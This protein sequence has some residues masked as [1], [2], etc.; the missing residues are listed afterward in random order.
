MGSGRELGGRARLTGRDEGAKLVEER[1]AVF[2]RQ[3]FARTFDGAPDAV[4]VLL[5]GAAVESHGLVLRHEVAD[6]R[7]LA[8][9]HDDVASRLGRE[10][11]GLELGRGAAVVEGEQGDVVHAAFQAVAQRRGRQPGLAAEQPGS[12]VDPVDAVRDRGPAVRA[13]PLE[14]QEVSLQV[15][16]LADAPGVDG[17]LHGAGHRRETEDVTHLDDPAAFFGESVQCEGLCRLRGEG[18]LDEDV[19]A[20]LECFAHQ[21]GVGVGRRHDVDGI[22]RVERGEGIAGRRDR[23]LGQGRRIAVADRQLYAESLPA[24]DMVAPPAPG[25]DLQNTHVVRTPLQ[26][27]AESASG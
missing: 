5:M 20:P 15:A 12:H 13:R 6:D 8:T 16:R 9:H 18:L 19:L 10:V 23:E 25:A 3:H 7:A 11:A 2:Q 26:P 27:R 1:L 4:G 17:V 21:R 14:A 22:H 24:A